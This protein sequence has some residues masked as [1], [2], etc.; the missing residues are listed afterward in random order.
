MF[1]DHRQNFERKLLYP[2]FGGAGGFF[3]HVRGMYSLVGRSAVL[4]RGIALASLVVDETAMQ[5]AGG[6]Q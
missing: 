2:A 4:L 6:S 3:F 5:F 1:K